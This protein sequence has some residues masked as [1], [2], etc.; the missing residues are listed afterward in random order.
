MMKFASAFVVL[1]LVAMPAS[2]RDNF[3]WRCG[4]TLVIVSVSQKT[5]S[6]AVSGPKKA[7]DVVTVTSDPS[8]TPSTSGAN[9]RR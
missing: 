1:T 6:V 4:E 8:R 5:I 3:A 9:L 7:S 2:A